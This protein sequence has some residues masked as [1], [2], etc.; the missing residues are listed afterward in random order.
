MPFRLI[1]LGVSEKEKQLPLFSSLS[2]WKRHT[3]KMSPDF[4]YFSI[5]PL[6]FNKPKPPSFFQDVQSK[7]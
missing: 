3:L 6:Q 4:L 1:P 7:N 2:I 5:I